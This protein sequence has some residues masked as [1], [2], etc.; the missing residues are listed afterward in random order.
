MTLKSTLPV[1][2]GASSLASEAPYVS[3]DLMTI[4]FEIAKSNMATCKYCSFMGTPIPKGSPKIIL[5]TFN[6]PRQVSICGRCAKEF[7]ENSIEDMQNII[8][9]IGEDKEDSLCL[10]TTSVSL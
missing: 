3:L 6:P 5:N 7:L 2:Q 1:H 10:P 8:N 4:K 9:E